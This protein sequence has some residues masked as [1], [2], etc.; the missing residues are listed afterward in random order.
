[1]A[2]KHQKIAKTNF[3]CLHNSMILIFLIFRIVFERTSYGTTVTFTL[4][5]IRRRWIW[6]GRWWLLRVAHLVGLNLAGGVGLSS[7]LVVRWV[8]HGGYFWAVVF[9][10]LGGVSTPEGPHLPSMWACFSLSQ[11]VGR[12]SQKRKKKGKERIKNYIYFNAMWSRIIQSMHDV[13][14]FL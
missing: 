4:N 1:M 12:L 8:V 6:L 3:F 5:G 7:C 2:E 11:L 9:G 14:F 13:R 10:S